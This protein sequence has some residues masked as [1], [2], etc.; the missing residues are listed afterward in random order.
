MDSWAYHQHFSFP[1]RNAAALLTR[2]ARLASPS[3][4]GVVK[5]GMRFLYLF[6]VLGRTTAT[7]TSFS[8]CRSLHCLIRFSI[9]FEKWVVVNWLSIGLLL[10]FSLLPQLWVLDP[11]FVLFCPNSSSILSRTQHDCMNRPRSIRAQQCD[12][13]VSV[14]LLHYLYPLKNVYPFMFVSLVVYV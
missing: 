9:Y 8:P 7:T 2:L 14:S 3:C 11:L 10:D 13:V 6:M 12:L 4:R 5:I 1:R